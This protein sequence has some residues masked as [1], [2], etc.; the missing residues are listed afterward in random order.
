[1]KKVKSMSFVVCLVFILL[2]AGAVTSSVS[3]IAAGPSVAEQNIGITFEDDSSQDDSSDPN[4]LQPDLGGNNENRP[5][6]NG[7][8]QFPQTGEQKTFLYSLIGF[9]ILVILFGIILIN[10]QRREQ[11]KQ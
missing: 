5:N 11:L 8:S 7:N 3:A 4:V 6:G 2:L 1:M 10:K 9:W